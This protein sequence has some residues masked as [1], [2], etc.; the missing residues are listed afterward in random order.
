MYYSRS[1][2]LTDISS[3]NSFNPSEALWSTPN[4]VPTINR[5]LSHYLRAMENFRGKVTL[6]GAKRISTPAKEGAPAP[7]DTTA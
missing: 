4:Q 5:P 3:P 2:S 6:S 1:V 7:E